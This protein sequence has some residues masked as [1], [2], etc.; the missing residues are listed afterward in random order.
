[1]HRC[2]S[3]LLPAGKLAL[4]NLSHLFVIYNRAKFPHGRTLHYA[5][6]TIM[7]CGNLTIDSDRRV[8][9]K[10]DI[11]VICPHVHVVV[12]WEAWL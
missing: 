9:R 8:S 10:Q 1:M 3:N 11:K 6:A 2:K 12:Y 7:L 4:L 5:L